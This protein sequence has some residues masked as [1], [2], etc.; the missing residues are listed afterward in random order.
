MFSKIEF[1]QPYFLLLLLIIPLLIVWYVF[2]HRKA[3]ADIQ[4]STTSFFATSA[5]TIKHYFFHIL[6]AGRMLAIALLIVAFARP[7]SSLSRKDVNIEGIDIV[8]ALDISTS[9]LA[10]DFKPNRLG[11]SMEVAKE[12]IDGR[13]DDN[14]GLVIF[15][16]ESFTQCPLT[17]DHTTLK[18]LFTEI[19]IGMIEDGTALGDGLST[20]V[21]RLKNS[22]AISKVIVLL[23]DGVNNR[24]AIDP[25]TSAEIA[26]LFGIRVY[27]IGVGTRGK[28]LSPVGMYPNGHYKYASVDVDI[29]EKTLKE[30]AVLTDGKYFRAV[31]K[32]K[33]R[34][35]YEEINK[36][37][38]SKIDVTEFRRKNDE[39]LLL[40]LIAVGLLIFEV[41]I[42]TTVLKTFP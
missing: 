9:M 22:K 10:K 6:F 14:I 21:N 27:T 34:G 16:G 33:L 18:N 8:L 30:M 42:R 36:L 1:E 3:Y 25:V 41:L 4:V 24:G 11:A 26:K 29:D 5:K 13:P 17:T 28:A 37:E 40:T 19:K 38:K 31:N 23:T 32:D 7:Q 15:S 12:F 20:A 2:R 35:V 39:Y